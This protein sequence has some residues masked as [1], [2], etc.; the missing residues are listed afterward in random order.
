[1]PELVGA[2]P[3]GDDEPLG[4]AVQFD[5]ADVPIGE[6]SFE[7]PLKSLIDDLTPLF[8]ERMISG[9]PMAKDYRVR[10]LR[11]TRGHRP[12]SSGATITLWML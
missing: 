9:R 3:F 6:L 1:V 2:V 8:G 10:E 12:S 5:S 11:I 7:G 4:M